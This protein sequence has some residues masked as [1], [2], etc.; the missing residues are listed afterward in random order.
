MK[1]LAISQDLIL[2]LDAATQTCAFIARKRPT[3]RSTRISLLSRTVPTL[4]D[5]RDIRRQ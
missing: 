3:R 1:T 4:K 5:E 2:P